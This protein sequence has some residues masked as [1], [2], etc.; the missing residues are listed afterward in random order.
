ML[1]EVP[2]TLTRLSSLTLFPAPRRL[3]GN[4]TM[5]CEPAGSNKMNRR[6]CKPLSDT[7]HG[8]DYRN[9]AC[10]WLIESSK[11]IVPRQLRL[12]RQFR[13]DIRANASLACWRIDYFILGSFFNRGTL[14]LSTSFKKKDKKE[15]TRC[16]GMHGLRI[17]V[18]VIMNRFCCLTGSIDLSPF[19]V[20]NSSV[21][22]KWIQ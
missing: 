14:S 7:A 11:V 17:P 22:S 16:L 21:V 19:Q 12:R 9:D 3:D 10:C 6:S 20:K 2:L 13:S 18:R 15:V 8:I 4:R 5:A 1:E